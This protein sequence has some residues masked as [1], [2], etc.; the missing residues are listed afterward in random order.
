M[1]NFIMKLQRAAN[2][3]N[4]ID[5]AFFKIYLFTVGILF[6]VYFASYWITCIDVIWVMATLSC[7]Y[8]LVRLARN[9]LKL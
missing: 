4:V 3:F 9:Y 1:K 8:T 7:V 5:F 6:G 2:Q